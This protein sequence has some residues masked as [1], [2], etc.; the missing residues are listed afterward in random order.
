MGSPLNTLHGNKKRGQVTRIIV[1]FTEI[2]GTKCG[3]YLSLENGKPR[4]KFDGCKT[5][6]NNYV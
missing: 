4:F 2:V 3:I 6:R 1:T 5:T